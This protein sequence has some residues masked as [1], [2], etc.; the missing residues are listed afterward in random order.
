MENALAT[1]TVM[2]QVNSSDEVQPL[3]ETSTHCAQIEVK[4]DG[5]L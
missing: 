5:K 1:L 2:F 4:V 3:K